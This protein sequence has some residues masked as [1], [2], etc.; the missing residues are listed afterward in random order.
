MVE[1]FD[2]VLSCV[3]KVFCC[4]VVGVCGCMLKSSAVYT[5]AIGLIVTCTM[6]FVGFAD[7][8][9]GVSLFEKSDMN[10]VMREDTAESAF[11]R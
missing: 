8:V 2:V 9:D 3:L 11:A 7:V 10:F 5:G 1:G 4:L 6:E